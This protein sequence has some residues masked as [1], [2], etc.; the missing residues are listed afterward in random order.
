MK[1]DRDGFSK[2]LDEKKK[3]ASKYY[4]GPV[5]PGILPTEPEYK[6]FPRPENRQRIIPR[7]DFRIQIDRARFY[8]P[9]EVPQ[10]TRKKLARTLCDDLLA[11]LMLKQFGDK[12]MKPN[13]TFKPGETGYMI[14]PRR[15]FRGVMVV[16]MRR[17]MVKRIVVEANPQAGIYQTV[18]VMPSSS[19]VAQYSAIFV[20]ASVE[21]AVNRTCSSFLPEEQRKQLIREFEEYFSEIP[22]E[23][24][25]ETA[26]TVVAEDLE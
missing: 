12:T 21:E 18:E 4:R 17:F 20:F 10:K 26:H 24:D 19:C 6:T 16:N 9:I 23:E 13:H 25:K 15:S 5:G 2:V 14:Y 1:R 7:M 3:I 22:I 8:Q 11:D